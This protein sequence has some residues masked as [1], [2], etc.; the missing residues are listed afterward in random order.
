M[1]RNE[2]ASLSLIKISIISIAML[3]LLG[4]GVKAFNSQVNNVKIILSNHYEMNVLTTKTKVSEILE[5]NHVIVLPEETVVPDLESEI[6]ED[7][8]IVITNASQSGSEII[9]LAQESQSISMDQIIGNYAP[10]TEKIVTE[11][12]VIPY[13][14]VTKDVSN[15]SATTTNKVLQNGKDGLKEVTYR[16]K[17]QNE[18]EIEKTVISE[19]ILTQPINKI[20]QVKTA[21]TSRS[22]TVSRTETTS[23][24]S[25]ASGT[26]LGK[27]KVTAY[28]SCSICCGKSNGITA[29]G[30]KAT[31]NHTIAAS[32]QFPIGTKLKINGTVYT[33]EDRGGAINGNKIDIYMS[34][35][36]QAL[37]W[38]VRYL[39][40]ERVN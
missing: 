4:I 31:P 20:V 23:T 33:V 32:S 15:G 29:A 17:Y 34:T 28:C 5:E 24:E 27:F 19:N 2:K 8:T 21:T 35:H 3:F 14:T 40:V 10:I 13:E 12:V 36:S 7:K 18:I 1:N 26:S 39:N 30:T 9:K 25:T 37:A 16:V 6:G 11:Q 38:G 22:T